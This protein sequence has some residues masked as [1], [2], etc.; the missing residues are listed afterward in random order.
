M[1][2][3]IDT[4]LDDPQTSSTLKG[5]TAQLFKTRVLKS[6]PAEPKRKPVPRRT[7]VL[8]AAALAAVAGLSWWL[9]A[10]ALRDNG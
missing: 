4:I 9:H 1:A 7:L 3:V 8:L 5:E 2:D 6:R 10:S